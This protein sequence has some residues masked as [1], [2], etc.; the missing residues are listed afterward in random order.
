MPTVEVAIERP[1]LHPG[2]Q[3]VAE[4]PARFKV[5]ACGRRWGKTRLGSLLAVERASTGGMVWWVAP[6]YPRA[7]IGWR[8]MKALVRQIPGT[9]VR[10]AERRV[11]FDYGG[12]LQV[13][14]AHDLGALRGEGLDRLVVD[15][16]AFMREEAWTLELRPALADKKGDAYF[17]STFDGENFFY[18]LYEV[19]QSDEHPDWMSWR[20]PTLA[21]PFIDPQE[22]DAARRTLPQAEFEQEFEANPLVYVGAVFPGE[23]VQEATERGSACEW[24]DDLSTFA[25]LDWGYT[26]ATAFEVCQE[27]AEGRTAWLDERSWV[28]TQLETRVSGIVELCR[29]RKIEAVYADA[30]GASE[31]AAL[32]AGLIDADLPT[33]VI[34]VPFGKKLRSGETAKDAG[35]KTRRWY[36]EN[37]L[38]AMSKDVPEL[39]RTTKRYHFK[40]GTEDVEKVDDH[41]VDAATCFYASR[42]YRVVEEH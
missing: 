31:N 35:I 11:E 37:D 38:E 2:Q 15:E 17:F 8:M 21:N 6:D 16:A 42:R 13:K 24:R 26:N 30:A 39:I 28:A 34:A 23:K 9:T 22:I 25:G 10:E 20:F 1:P 36:L 41:P 7:T 29:L 5:I 3:E 18:D 40:E 19:G 4:H 32:K 12:A 14:S 33:E 27:D